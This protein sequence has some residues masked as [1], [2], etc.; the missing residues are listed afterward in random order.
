MPVARWG[1][2]QT[3]RGATS[4]PVGLRILVICAA[5]LGA[6]LYI[7]TALWFD[8][9]YWCLGRFAA[10]R[11]VKATANGAIRRCRR[12]GLRRSCHIGFDPFDRL[13]RRRVAGFDRALLEPGERTEPERPARLRTWRAGR[14]GFTYQRARRPDTCLDGFGRRNR[15]PGRSRRRIDFDLESRG[16]AHTRA[17]GRADAAGFG[18][19]STAGRARPRS[20]AGRAQPRRDPGD[21]RLHDL[22]FGLDGHDPTGQLVHHRAQDQADERVRVSDL[23]TASYEEDHL[24]P[25]ELGGAAADPRNLWP[26]PYVAALADG[27]STGAHVKD[28]FENQLKRKVCAGSVTLAKARADIG[29]FWVHAYYNLELPPSPTSTPPTAAPSSVSPP[30]STPSQVAATPGQ[31]AG[32]GF[33]VALVEV[34]DPGNIGA[35]ASVTASTSPGAVC[36]IKVTLPSGNVSTVKALAVGQTAADDGRV[37]WVWTIASTTNPGT[38][39]AAVTC[40]LAGAS[41]SAQATFSMVK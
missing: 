40:K 38:A 26:E 33:K 41:A 11:V 28:Q 12:R 36:A 13:D 32:A 25:L 37:S 34:P 35:S 27:R 14:R 8:V 31:G 3:R 23:S 18:R 20:H 4:G 10:D 6:I 21:D 15:D 39:K 24:I 5:A 22:R 7:V 9:A 29:V 1:I 2:D 30:T 19:G 17:D 16:V